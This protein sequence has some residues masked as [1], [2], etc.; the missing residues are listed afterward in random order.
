MTPERWQRIEQVYFAALARTPD[1]R[2]ALLDE[3]CKGDEPLRAEVESL[4]AAHQ[5][6]SG[7]LAE[8]A[9]EFEAKN[10]AL[11]RRTPALALKAGQELSH[12]KILSRLGAGGMGEVFLAQDAILERR[13]ALKLLP[14]QFTEDAERLQRFIREAKAAS[15]L[16]HPNIIT[17]YEIGEI[18]TAQGQTHFIATEF[19][20]GETLRTWALDEEQRLRQALNIAMQMASALDAAHKAGIVHRDIKPENVMV[21]PDGLVKVL[22][23]GLAKLTPQPTDSEARTLIKSL[24]TQ[25][26]MILGTLRYMSPEQARGRGVDARSDIFSLGVVLYELLTGQPL[27]AGDTDADI[28]AAIIHKQAPPLAEHLSGVPAELER[29][30]QKALAKEKERRYQS[31]HDLQA[32]LQAV[33]QESE[34]TA[35]RA[36]SGPVTR[37][38]LTAQTSS[39]LTA[40]RFSLRQLLLVLIVGLLL[41]SVIGWLVMARHGN[42]VET[43][44]LASLQNVE[45]VRWASLPG[46]VYSTGAFSPDSK[47]IAFTSSKSGVRNIYVRQTVSGQDHQ[48]TK[49]EFTNESPIWSPTGEEIAF[50]SIERGD[51][52]G[53]WRMPMMGGPLTL[54]KVL[55]LDEASIRLLRWSKD[56]ATIYYD[57]KQQLFSL[58][59]QS[60]ETRPITHFDPAQVSASSFSISPDEQQIAYITTEANGHRSIWVV[61]LHGGTPKRIVDTAAASRNTAW[62]PDGE[63]LFYSSK[64]DGIYQI[65]V[66]DIKGHQPVQLTFGDRESFVV[67]VSADGAKVLYGSS[68]EQS[69]LWGIS[70]AKANEEFVVAS[71]ISC[72]LWPDISPDNKTV[73]YQAVRNL[74]QGNGIYNGTVLTQEIGVKA[75]AF[76]LAKDG[77]LPK[78]SP[79]GKQIA[80]VRRENES[81]SL[82]TINVAGGDEKTLVT[83]GLL[84]NPYSVLPYTRMEVSDFSWS[85]DGH[86]L[87]YCFSQAGVQNLRLISADGSG[88]TPV[89]NNQDANLIIYCPIWSG[90]AKRLAYATRPIKIATFEDNIY[91]FW[92]VD[93]ETRTAKPLV[94]LNANIHLLGWSPDDQ[95]LLFAQNLQKGISLWRVSVVTGKQSLVARVPSAKYYNVHLSPDR[96]LVAYVSDEDGEDNLRVIPA[97]GGMERQLTANK[98]PHLYFSTL[99]WSPDSRA[100]YYGKQSRYSLLSMITNFR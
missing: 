82:K 65:F 42:V 57:S 26:G 79:A 72:E 66:A 46:E 58:N 95:E 52:P 64:V 38:N 22:D 29:I 63:R 27:F 87:G 28:V 8:P 24:N 53:I 23:F 80:F 62:H 55:P 4:L 41:V 14:V 90:D 32:D 51:H 20:E 84:L 43:P 33:K 83:G 56:G 11:D 67:D 18:P 75:E 5:Q 15:A 69:D 60:G 78:W 1:Q 50:F 73:A 16:N 88:D 3:A 92:V 91:R 7:F 86:Q 96:R 97:G 59:V 100:I 13:V 99:A 10:L 77:F 17:I 40:P 71:D 31:A 48:S 49:D 68:E 61:P 81:F 70:L 89:T 2:A 94:Q 76:V 12:Y 37:V 25:P 6:G 30:V 98:A 44:P 45:V 54:L 39:M 93:L 47:W 34:L 74:S 85:P 19:I 21:R 9:L 36:R 35:R